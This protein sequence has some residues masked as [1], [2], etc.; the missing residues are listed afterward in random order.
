MF[1]LDTKA[2]VRCLRTASIRGVDPYDSNPTQA[3]VWNRAWQDK[4]RRS[5][6]EA[7]ANRELGV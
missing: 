4:A 6:S 5:R 7:D 2:L 1:N 3:R